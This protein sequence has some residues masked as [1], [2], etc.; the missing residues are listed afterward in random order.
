MGLDCVRKTY[1][2][3]NVADWKVE[4]VTKKGDTISSIH[5]ERLGKIYKLTV[6]KA[7]DGRHFKSLSLL[8][9]VFVLLS[10]SV[11]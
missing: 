7:Y 1:N 8:C 6:S 4:K 3:L 11:V 9:M 10:C 5:R 2:L